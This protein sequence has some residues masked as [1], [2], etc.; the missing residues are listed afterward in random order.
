MTHHIARCQGMLNATQN[1][2]QKPTKGLTIQQE[3][4]S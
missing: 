1:N 4:L 2:K 3:D